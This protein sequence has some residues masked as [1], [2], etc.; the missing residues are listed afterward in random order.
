MSSA[1]A[2][3]NN[4]ASDQP[5]RWWFRPARNSLAQRMVGR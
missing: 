4:Q 1:P 2:A 5:T 3:S